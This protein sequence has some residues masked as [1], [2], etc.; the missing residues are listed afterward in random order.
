M[1]A[2]G[3]RSSWETSAIQSSV[4]RASATL[5]PAFAGTTTA[6]ALLEAAVAP[7]FGTGLGCRPAAEPWAA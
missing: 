7:G 3:R 2:I 6:E 4:L 5:P 1:L